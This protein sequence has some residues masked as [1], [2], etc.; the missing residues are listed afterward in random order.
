[1]PL[2]SLWTPPEPAPPLDIDQWVRL[3]LDAIE[4]HLNAVMVDGWPGMSTTR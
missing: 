3:E 1:M 2:T 4:A